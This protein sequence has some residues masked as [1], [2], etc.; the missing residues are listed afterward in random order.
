MRVS[1]HYFATLR[2]QRGVPN[3]VVELPEAT[4]AAAAYA[5]LGLPVDLPVAFAV[6][7]ERVSG[8]TVLHEGDEVA[9]LPPLGGG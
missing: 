8:A 6:N 7:L 4:T 3:E 1:V 2:D 9:F 5:H